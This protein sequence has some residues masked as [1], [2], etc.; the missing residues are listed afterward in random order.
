MNKSRNTSSFSLLSLFIRY[1]KFSRFNA[2]VVLGFEMFRI[3]I[4]LLVFGGRLFDSV[5]CRERSSSMC[6][7]NVSSPWPKLFLNRGWI[8]L[9]F[10]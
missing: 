7:F 9:S 8:F 6:F 5:W 2:E 4:L 3:F 1:S 10:G